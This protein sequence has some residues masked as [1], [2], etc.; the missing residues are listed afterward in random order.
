[1]SHPYAVVRAEIEA[2]SLIAFLRSTPAR[3][4]E[5]RARTAWELLKVLKECRRE[6]VE[7]WLKAEADEQ[8][9]ESPATQIRRKNNQPIPLELRTILSLLQEFLG[10]RQSIPTGDGA[11]E[12]QNEHR[13][14]K[15]KQ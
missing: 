3:F 15:V 8:E 14:R 4:G 10:V 5:Q 11:I 2:R 7:E 13:I 1:M 12:L 9:I 6:R